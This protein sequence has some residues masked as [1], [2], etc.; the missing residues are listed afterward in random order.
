MGE[1]VAGPAPHFPGEIAE[2]Q[3]CAAG[4]VQSSPLFLG[5]KCFFFAFSMTFKWVKWVAI[6]QNSD[7]PDSRV[8]Q[9]HS[10]AGRGSLGWGLHDSLCFWYREKERR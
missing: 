1:S 6:W 5:L 2:S 10:G 7:Q 4:A 9:F 3:D 8:A